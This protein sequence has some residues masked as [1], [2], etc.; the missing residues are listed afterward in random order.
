MRTFD[1]AGIADEALV[2]VCL[3]QNPGLFGV[4]PEQA[5]W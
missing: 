4:D 5:R 3:T 2:A 1:L